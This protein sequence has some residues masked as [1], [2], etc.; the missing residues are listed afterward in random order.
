MYMNDTRYRIRNGIIAYITYTYICIGEV[1][2]CKSKSLTKS[3]TYNNMPRYT[4]SQIMNEYLCIYISY[5]FTC[6]IMVYIDALFY[7]HIKYLNL[8]GFISGVEY[9]ILKMIFSIFR[10]KLSCIRD[11]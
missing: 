9:T 10:N 5:N 2:L 11:R 4:K 7:T 6:L 1:V 3:L 8:S